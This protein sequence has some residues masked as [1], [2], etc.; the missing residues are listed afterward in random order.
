MPILGLAEERFDPHL[1]LPQRLTVGFGVLVIAHPFEVLLLEAA[2]YP[3]SLLLALRAAWLKRA[4]V[5][6]GGLGGVPDGPLLV[7]APL[8]TQGLA[9]GADVE[10]L[11]GVVN[12]LVLG[13]HRTAAFVVF[14]QHHVS[15]YA[16]LLHP[17]HVLYGA[18]G[19]IA[20]DRAGPQA[21]AKTAPKEQ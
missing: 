2:P 8:P 7:V 5:A 1:A 9:L 16:G 18:V 15:A 19:G 11:L 14:G 10:V 6:G 20:G 3:A 21:P 13:E 12:E 17:R 4:R